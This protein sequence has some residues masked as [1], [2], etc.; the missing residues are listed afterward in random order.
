MMTIA[1]FLLALEF[2]HQKA[3]VIHGDISMNNIMINR[4]WRH[5]PNDSP[6]Q[7]RAIASGYSNSIIYAK[8]HDNSTSQ[9]IAQA[10]S[11][12][13]AVIQ[14]P[15]TFT[16]VIQAS[17]TSAAQALVTPAP[18]GVVSAVA[19]SVA[20]VQASATPAVGQVP[21]TS[22]IIQA[23]ATSAVVQVPIPLVLSGPEPSTSITVVEEPAALAVVRAPAS[24]VGPPVAYTGTTEHIESSGMIIDCDFM[25]FEG[26]ETHLTSVRNPAAISL[27]IFTN[28]IIIYREHY[29]SC[30][31]RHY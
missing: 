21:V 10:S 26:Q 17:A 28:N 11:T 13:T 12:S 6:S 27:I 8:D 30:R 9:S 5:G 4:V 31:S 22:T 19:T 3:G 16:T 14:A 24:H 29:L 7:L 18:I 1:N 2:L 15:D 23:L 20:V 25:R